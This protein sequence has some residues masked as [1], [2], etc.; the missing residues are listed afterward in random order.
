MASQLLDQLIEALQCQPGVGPKSAQRIAYQ[1]LQNDRTGGLLLA[2]VLDAA[3]QHIGHCQWCRD[4]TEVPRCRICSSATRDRALL[5]VVERPSD[6]QAIESASF[7]QGL[8]FV[9][10]GKLSPLDGI[11]PG[12]L[13]LS[14]LDR[15]LADGEV[16]EVIL[17][18]SPTV[19]GEVTAQ[20][21]AERCSRY[22]VRLTRIAHGIPL[23]GDLDYVDGGT[24]S[25]AF[26]GRRNY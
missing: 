18:V 25:H 16:R 5:C 15:R 8:Y 14:D 3:M 4:F 24:L 6:V 9:L 10:G 1:L 21:L 22:A 26:A 11:G 23:G 2:E 19:E 12:E 7:Y 20:Y 17:A 13:R